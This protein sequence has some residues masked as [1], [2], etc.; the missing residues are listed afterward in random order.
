MQQISQFV[1]QFLGSATSI[2]LP[3]NGVITFTSDIP[4]AFTALQFSGSSFA[5]LPVVSSQTIAMIPT[6]VPGVGGAGALLL[7]QFVSGDGWASQIS[8]TN[9]L[10]VPQTVRV[11]LFGSDGT[12]QS[13]FPGQQVPANGVFTAVS[14]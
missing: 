10:N 5:T 6:T 9:L 11:D 4:V 3:L 7:P 12:L 2:T 13:T 8:I 14:Q 1:N